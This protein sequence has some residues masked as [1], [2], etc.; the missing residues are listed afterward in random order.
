MQ[1]YTFNLVY[2]NLIIKY[3]VHWQGHKLV[4]NAIKCIWDLKE[5][6]LVF[7]PTVAL[8]CCIERVPLPFYC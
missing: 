7:Q 3:I 5:T 8:Q 1:Q 2:W 4:E 6:K